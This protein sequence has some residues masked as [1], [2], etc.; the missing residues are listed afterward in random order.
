[1]ID[2]ANEIDQ[3]LELLAIEYRAALVYNHSA[4]SGP[5]TGVKH[6]RLP[7]RSSLNEPAAE[8]LQEQN[9]KLVNSIGYKILN[10]S[11]AEIGFGVNG[12]AGQPTEAL[13]ANEYG[14]ED[15]TRQG[16]F[17]LL[18]TMES[19]EVKRDALE[20]VKAVLMQ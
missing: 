18:R 2:F 12:D 19:E 16:R 3:A 15:G 4:A 14:S 8:F 17:G 11:T 13:L 1:M 9:G 6:I 10:T 5:R 20:V 7:R